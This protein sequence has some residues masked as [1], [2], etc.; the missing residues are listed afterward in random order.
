MAVAKMKKLSILAE[1]S[2]KELLLE[3]I[4]ELQDIEFVNLPASYED[5][6]LKDF[7]KSSNMDLQ[8]EINQKLQDIKQ[9]IDF[10]T[11]YVSQPNFL[12]KLKTKREVFTLKELEDSIEAENLSQTIENVSLKEEKVQKAEEHIKNLEE[13]EEFLRKWNQLDFTFKDIENVEHFHITVGSIDA[14]RKDKLFDEFREVLG[15][16]HREIYTETIFETEME[17]AYLFIMPASLQTEVN[18]ILVRNSFQK[19]TYPYQQPPKKELERVLEERSQEVDQLKGE[20]ASLKGW[21]SELKTLRLGEEYYSN[22][23]ERE[24]VKEMLVNSEH[25]FIASGWIPEDEMDQTLETV[26]NDLN[27]N[28]AL[29]TEDI[30]REEYGEVP[31]KLKNNKL[32][33]PFEGMTSQFGLPQY[34]EIDPTPFYYPFQI[35]FFGIMSADFGYGLLLFLGT[36]IPLIVGDLDKGLRKNLKMFNQMSIGTMVV[37]LI[38]GSFFG[39]EMP[40]PHVPIND[41]VIPLMI[42]SVAIGVIHMLLA[43]FIN[44]YQTS[45]D[46]AYKASYLEGWQWIMI[47]GGAILIAL[48]M[49]FFDVS[50]LNT[51][52]ILLILGNILLMLVVNT[53]ASEKKFAGFG[54]GL[55]GLMDYAGAIGDVVSYTRLAALAVSSANIA[56]AFNLIIGLFP[57]FLRFTVGILLFIVLQGLNIFITFL[58]SY[59]HSMRLEF[60]EFFGKFFRTGGKAFEPLKTVDKHTWVKH[61]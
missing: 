36:L 1:Q 2:N 54:Q 6:I 47:Y 61:K 37:G 51:I 42:F 13:E 23:L 11:N 24:K 38:F 45:R 12:K 41:A 53:I 35:I 3:S 19:L 59:V 30:K 40:T 10:L 33:E 20:K 17:I 4:Q 52:G 55:L 5:E 26:R 32:V 49:V 28:V 46:N 16:V 50:A 14:E 21:E 34:G 27:N 39:F 8:S 43:F 7:E 29:L 25:L 31:I 60:V 56:F 22:L 15:E 48:N 18:E 58:G 9:N 44:I 57:P